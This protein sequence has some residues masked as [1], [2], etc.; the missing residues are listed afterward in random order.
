VEN[1]QKLVEIQDTIE[2]LDHIDP[3]FDLVS[4]SRFLIREDNAKLMSKSIMKSDIHMFL[5]NDLLLLT[6][7]HN[8]IKPVEVRVSKKNHK[9]HA[10]AIIPLKELLVNRYEEE[11][12]I[13]ELVHSN[14]NHIYT[15]QMSSAEERDLFMKELS[16]QMDKISTAT[17]W[18]L[19]RSKHRHSGN[20]QSESKLLLDIE[21]KLRQDAQETIEK[22]SLELNQLRTRTELS[23]SSSAGETIEQNEL[24]NM[25]RSIDILKKELEESRREKEEMQKLNS[26]LV[27]QL[28]QIQTERFEKFEKAQEEKKKKKREEKKKEKE[29]NGKSSHREKSQES[30]TSDEDKKPKK[31]K[32]EK[33]DKKETVSDKDTKSDRSDKTDKISK[34]DKS[35]KSDRKSKELNILSK[36]DSKDSMEKRGKHDHHE[37]DHS[38]DKVSSPRPDRSKSFSKPKQVAPETSPA[39]PPTSPATEL[40]IPRTRS[41]PRMSPET[42]R[43]TSGKG[44]LANKEQSHRHHDSEKEEGRNE[45]KDKYE[46]MKSDI[47][48]L[49]KKNKRL[50]EDR[51]QLRNKVEELESTVYFYLDIA[52]GSLRSSLK[53]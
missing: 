45:S 30:I 11:L 24:V 42:Q 12:E 44:E 18:M 52:N 26:S 19:F 37:K 16:E 43:K 2:D 35:D 32:K 22:M 8:I 46:E 15:L 47:A 14:N 6:K 9:Y 49:K 41:V 1:V 10:T 31:E 50:K 34:S 5:F 21:H 36:A 53:K 23:K 48:H 20:F 17:K 7:T 13:I 3:A 39:S 51:T 38:H 25:K 4:H 28:Q 29:S 40:K 33:K 27:Q